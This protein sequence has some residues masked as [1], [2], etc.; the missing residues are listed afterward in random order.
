M[1]PA[2]ILLN[3]LQFV[4]PS[5]NFPVTDDHWDSI[6]DNYDDIWEQGRTQI[7]GMP[8]VDSKETIEGKDEAQIKRILDYGW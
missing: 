6:I 5:R 7:F 1:Q 4:L 3:F 8:F 2:E